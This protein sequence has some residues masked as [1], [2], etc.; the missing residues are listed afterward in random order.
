VGKNRG[1]MSLA[2]KGIALM[3]YSYA[4]PNT[5]LMYAVGIGLTAWA[6]MSRDG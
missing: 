4:V 3:V 6:W 2:M 1:N 5:L